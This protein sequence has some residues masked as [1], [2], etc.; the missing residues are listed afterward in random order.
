MRAVEAP[1]MTSHSWITASCAPEAKRPSGNTHSAV[2]ESECPSRRAVVPRDVNQCLA[3]RP[4]TSIGLMRRNPLFYVLRMR[5][6][7]G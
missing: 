6:R 2:I 4:P 5:F 7:S 3:G 1:L